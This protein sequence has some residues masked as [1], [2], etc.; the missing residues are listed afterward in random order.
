MEIV[1]HL[2]ATLGL[3]LVLPLYAE[4]ARPVPPRFSLANM[5]RSVDPR[6]DFAQFAFGTWMKN[7]PI[8]EDKSR[9]GGFDELAQY[10]W[11][12]LKDILETTA[13]GSHEP[14]SVEQKVGDFFASALNET[15]IA[16]AGIDPIAGDL[17]RIS[18]IASPGEF[19]RS[20]ARLHYQGVGGVFAV[21]VAADQKNSDSNALYAWQ[22]GEA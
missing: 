18:D 14:G 20:L 9:W 19:A 16:T 15:A 7:N 4:S 13:A 17:A 22:G 6:A 3:M 21:Y 1:R 10:N 5:D 11:A 8:P 2:T 12:A